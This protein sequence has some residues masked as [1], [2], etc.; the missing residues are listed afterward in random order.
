[1]AQDKELEIRRQFLDE[2]QEY[3]DVLDA[4][5]LDL[6]NHPI[7]VAKANAALRA[8]HS[9]KGGAGMMGFQ[10]LS[11][12]A[13]R[14]EDSWKVL[15]IDKS[16]V[17]SPRLENL[18][19][20]SVGCLRQ[21]VE[22]DRESMQRHQDSF[23]DANWLSV[24]AYPVF[25][26]LHAELGDPQEENAASILS[27]E[28]GQDIVPLL[29]ETEVE[30][31]LERLETVLNTPDQPCLREE[32]AILAQELGG[33]GE[34]LQLSQFVQL[35][36]SIA[37]AIE[38][39]SQNTSA[40]AE[41]ALT[42]W[43]TAQKLAIAGQYD[44][45]PTAIAEST[46][47]PDL[48]DFAD[49]PSVLEP[50]VGETDWF[51]EALAAEALAVDDF[52]PIPMP[53]RIPVGEPKGTDF[54]ILDP[55]PD[56]STATEAQDTTVRVP[57]RQLNQLNDSFGEL[58]IDRNGLDL[59]LK[60]LRGLARTLHDR[61]QVLDQV[62]AKLRTAYD[63]VT[64]DGS[65]SLQDNRRSGFDAL[66]LDRY[67]D[68]HLLSQQVM[69]TIVQLQEVSEDI[70]L[71]LDDADQSARNLTKTAKQL[72]S[73]LTQLRMRPISDVI[74]RFPR[75][76]REWSL[77]YGKEVQLSV[78][79]GSTLI[80]RNLLE[81][82]ND[83]LM[84]LI[85]NAFDH[86]IEEPTLRALRGKPPQGTIEI[87]AANQGN[88]TIITVRDDG[89]GIPIDK[90][91]DRAEQMGLDPVLLDAARDEELLS[92]IFEPGFSTST[93]VTALSGRGVGM[94]VV[95]NNLK[96]IRGEISVNT[97]AGQGTTFTLS[98]PFA[99]STIKVLLIECHGMLLALPTDVV[100]ELFLLQPNQIIETAGS[101]VL[102]W[103]DKVV[104]LVRLQKW[105]RFNC[106]QIP[107][108]FE[109]PPT[110]AMTSVVIIDQ[111][112]QWFGI[113]IDRCWG[114]QEATMRK[115]E[116][117]LAL[118]TG[119]SGCTILGDG[120]VVPLVNVTELL[121][122]I[123]SCER[124]DIQPDQAFSKQLRASLVA[125][126][127]SMAR[128]TT[129]TILVVDDSINVRR[130]LALTLERSGYRVEQA[131]DGQDA[132]ERLEAGLSVQAVICDIEMPRLD[133]YGF[134]AK[135]R[136]DEQ[137]AQIPVMMLTSRSGEKH[138]KV[139]ENLGAAAY[140]SKPYNE[141]VLLRTLEGMV[142]STALV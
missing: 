135:L 140:F 90:I 141:Q 54:K 80:D 19:L 29:F 133:G 82:L 36:Q 45:I 42:A 7:D 110:I 26:A 138:R 32:V 9:I 79:G 39:D 6:A 102:N 103:Q 111:A 131:K 126:Q 11:E 116:G 97:Q 68:L 69:E 53:T 10:V 37:Y 25:D 27:P 122:W 15:K 17:V 124:S 49:V 64:L 65:R 62:N 61:V 1:M 95:R 96:Q 123:T 89:E 31:C 142:K 74:N 128:S 114:E 100:S 28:E 129:P 76:I 50:N 22:F 120:R 130:F 72:Q 118:P 104:Q 121:R 94:D 117:N 136:S 38:Q 108:G 115:V 77:Q 55:E 30:G 73:G 48:A 107:H 70:D 119:F 41:S 112:P 86:G 60:R 3:L 12:L 63:R 13:H 20:A 16:I 40:I 67:G 14:L 2:A 99:L 78:V 105:M 93:Q 132:I 33:L 92:L 134:L 109:T 4:T 23:V 71:S 101:E 47:P 137:L 34:M 8:A 66:E 81:A 35:C 139:A 127:P 85:R 57:V 24:E 43:R 91:R 52:Q 21:V 75:A 84:H 83:P 106:P 113:Q 87:Q 51:T 18:L 46:L 88:R 5:I 125:S 98:I 44:Q 58:T 59:Y 56:I